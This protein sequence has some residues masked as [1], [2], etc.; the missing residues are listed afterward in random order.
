[1]MKD[2][3][4]ARTV[5]HSLTLSFSSI[6][7]IF[8]F[9]CERV[10]ELVP[11]WCL[12]YESWESSWIALHSQFKCKGALMQGIEVADDEQ[13]DK[14]ITEI[15]MIILSEAVWHHRYFVR[16]RVGVS[17]NIVVMMIYCRPSL[18]LKRDAEWFYILNSRM[19]ILD[20]N[21]L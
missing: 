6:S 4:W 12:D 2:T 11:Q 19:H 18:T 20:T 13:N 16:G 15:L 17:K 14:H 10:D 1:M 5:L 7:T 8:L 21:G 9:K 3:M